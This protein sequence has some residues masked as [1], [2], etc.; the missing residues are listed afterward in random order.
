M[1]KKTYK[2]THNKRGYI[3]IFVILLAVT[4]VW[5]VYWRPAPK[6]PKPESEVIISQSLP[7]TPTKKG[8]LRTFTGEQFRDLY[9]NFAYP[10]TE[11]ISDDTPITGNPEA[12]KY[13]RKLAESRG[14]VKRS[15]PITNNF[16]S[17]GKEMTL[18][19]RA[20][21][22]WLE[23]QRL[24]KKDGQLLGL[25]AAYRSADE[26]REI[27]LDRIGQINLNLVPS[28]TYDI[29]IIQILS[30]T[31]LPGYSRHHTG[32]TVDIICENDPVVAFEYSECFSWLSAE[33]YKNT[34]SFGWIPSYPEGAGSQ[35]P[36]PESWE[37][38]WVGLDAL[39]E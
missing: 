30:T 26:Q 12:D 11:Y 2:K 37:Y 34:K 3:L 5:W 29:R 4:G 19:E 15:A 27:F 24:A 17:V 18:Q 8:I 13:I 35:G 21:K 9:N 20:A 22:P 14:Y 32:Y 25:S 33:N 7:E 28:G 36:E 38:V 23:M 10:N 1:K 6:N 39:T 31:A 16:I